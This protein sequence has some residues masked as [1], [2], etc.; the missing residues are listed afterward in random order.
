MTVFLNAITLVVRLYKQVLPP[1]E[2]PMRNC[3]LNF[4]LEYQ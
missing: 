2:C 1:S 4:E 3:G